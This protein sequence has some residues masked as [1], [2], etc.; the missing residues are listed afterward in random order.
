[1]PYPGNQELRSFKIIKPNSHE[2]IYL[3]LAVMLLSAAMFL[4][5]HAIVQA[6]EKKNCPAVIRNGS[7][8]LVTNAQVG[9]Q[10]SSAQGSENGTVVYAETQT[11]TTNGNDL[12]SIP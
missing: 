3:K 11:P 5:Q 6:P 4:P 9:M 8:D 12:V 7:D 10:L 2:K 1:M